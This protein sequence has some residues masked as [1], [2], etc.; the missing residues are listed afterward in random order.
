MAQTLKARDVKLK[1]MQKQCDDWNAV[2]PVGSVVLIKLDGRDE[3]ELT[4]SRSAA[5]ILS[6]HSVVIWLEN[7]SG[8]YQ[9]DHVR[10]APDPNEL[11]AIAESL[12]MKLVAG[13][14]GIENDLFRRRR[15][16]QTGHHLA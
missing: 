16:P 1:T 7:V 8:C 13:Y 15:N 11:G 9:L 4:K 10:A 5:Q 2:N 3:P 12:K 6:G 14:K